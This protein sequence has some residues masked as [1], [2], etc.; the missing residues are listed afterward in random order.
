[1]S[2][3][4]GLALVGAIFLIARLWDVFVDPVLGIVSDRLPT[5]WG[6][7]SRSAA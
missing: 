2:T 4:H 3:D 1:M 6:R 7:R 5:R